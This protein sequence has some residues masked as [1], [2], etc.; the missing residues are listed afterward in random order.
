M[1]F[2]DPDGNR[3]SLVSL[4]LKNSKRWFSKK[5]PKKTGGYVFKQ[6]KFSYFSNP[7]F[8]SKSLFN[9]HYKKHGK[10]FGPISEKTYLKRAQALVNSR[11]ARHIYAK[12]R[13]NGDMIIYNKLT[14][15][16]G[17]ISKK[18]KIRTLFKPKKGYQYFLVKD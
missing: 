7:K 12:H 15:E 4:F 10:E 8:A 3:T 1:I 17:V 14:N 6:V 11:P 2:F 16:Y 13:D 18:G 5:T 9:E